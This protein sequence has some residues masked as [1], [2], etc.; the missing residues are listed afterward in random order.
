[1]TKYIVTTDEAIDT[2]LPTALFKEAEANGTLDQE[3]SDDLYNEYEHIVV[4]GFYDANDEHEAR[5]L[6]VKDLIASDC[7]TAI[8]LTI[9]EI[10]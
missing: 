6:A 1:M 3:D 8:D 10:K 4:I 9:I 2:K 5:A 7:S